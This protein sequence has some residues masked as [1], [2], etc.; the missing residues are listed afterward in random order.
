[1]KARL[2]ISLTLAAACLCGLSS[3]VSIVGGGGT[4]DTA[5]SFATPSAGTKAAVEGVT[6]TEGSFLV[7]GG[8]GDDA[9]SINATNVFNGDTV[10]GLGGTWNYTGGTRY[11]VAGKTYDFYAVYPAG[12]FSGQSGTSTD[13][14]SV[15]CSPDGTVTINDFDASATGADAVD[16]MTA[17][18]SRTTSDPIGADETNAVPFQFSHALTRI[19]FSAKLDAGLTGYTLQVQEINLRAGNVGKM[20]RDNESVLQWTIEPYLNDD[21][22][23]NKQYRYCLYW[24]TSE[25]GQLVQSDISTDPIKLNVQ[26]SGDLLVIPQKMQETQPEIKIKYTLSYNGATTNPIEKSFPLKNNGTD[27]TPGAN[28]NYTFT[29]NEDNAYFSID[30][31][32]WVD[33]NS[34]NEDISFE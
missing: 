20:V 1:M 11:W 19:T 34:G 9:S 32:D 25:D 17:S 7:W 21:G 28:L 30:V 33:G 6:L 5:I 2:N 8:Y 29:I 12:I 4:G 13:T 16:L 27:W 3:C 26:T 22:S 10:I 24:L 23:V 15:T 18:V 31:G 14:P